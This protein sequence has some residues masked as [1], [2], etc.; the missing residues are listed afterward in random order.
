MRYVQYYNRSLN[1]INKKV[2]TNSISNN[3]FI[4]LTFYQYII[5]QMDIHLCNIKLYP[6]H[7][8][9]YLPWKIKFLDS[10]LKIENNYPHTHNDT[11][12]FNDNYFKFSQKERL[13]L[14]IHEK[15]HIY[16]RYYP[17]PYHFILFNIFKLKPLQLISTHKDYHKVRKNP[18][19]ND[20]LYGD[21]GQYTLAIFNENAKTIADVEF[22]DYNTHSKDTVYS[23]MNRNEHPNETFAYYIAKQI[24]DNNVPHNIT[25]YL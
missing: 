12:F 24:M 17:I 15:I 2:R 20:I 9:Y 3:V 6:F 16:Q 8:L 23:K 22:M 14:L 19:N 4:S 18:D 21:N 1:E 25:K 11:I 13:T 10:S 5:L 7:R